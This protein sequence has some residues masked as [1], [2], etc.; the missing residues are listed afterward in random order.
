M[1]H[2]ANS[3]LAQLARDDSRIVSIST[4]TDATFARAWETTPQRMFLVESGVPYALQWCADLALNGSRPFAFLSCEEAQNSFGQI[5]QD[6]CLRRAPVTMILE[7]RRDALDGEAA[8]SASLAGIRQL[9]HTCLLAPK[10]AMEVREMITWCASQNGPAVIWLPENVEPRA[11]WQPGPDIALG[12]AE[13]LTEGND[14]A[15]IAWG[16]MVASAC[17]AAETLAQLGVRAAVLNARFAQPL[18]I[19]ALARVTRGALCTVIVNDGDNHGGFSSWVLDELLG[20]GTAQN[21]SVVSP[22]REW[23]RQH[24]HQVHDECAA[25]IVERCRWLGERIET[26][27][28]TLVEPVAG[29]VPS[30]A[31]AP[32]RWLAPQGLAVS[33]VHDEQGEIQA[34]QFTPLVD[35]WVRRYSNVGARDVYLWR[36]CLHGLGLITLSCAPPRLRQDLCDTKLLAV[37]YGVMLDDI[38]DQ[39]GEEDFLTE[40]ANIIRGVPPDFSRFSSR[41]QAY[42]RFTD[43]LWK[44]FESRLKCLPCYD[45]YKELLEYDHQQI[46]NTM[47]YSSLVNRCPALLNVQEHDMYLP[48]N[49]QMLS[50]ATMDLMASP[51]F[52]RRELGKLREVI[53][54]AQ[55][56]GR[57]GNLVS[58]WQR[59]VGD[60]DF[61]SG[62]FARA[63]C[64]GDITLEDLRS[65]P[66]GAIAEAICNGGH[67]FYF[68][69][70]WEFHRASIEALGPRIHSVDVGALL[71]ALQ[72]LLHMELGSRGFK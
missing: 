60:R 59:E 38:A 50:F 31:T 5:R 56:M 35:D 33:E 13:Q 4:A 22:N 30:G 27:S 20:L 21:V 26:Q 64:Q 48:H 51:D 44:T 54:H 70:K 12:R 29:I 28:Q 23:R 52:D 49:M 2:V 43:D 11:V 41:Q 55:S 7:S 46:L 9:P 1:R 40:L 34:Q 62:V 8:S 63:L 37:M 72:R 17:A 14:V 67:E 36:W 53:W 71:M 69:Q 65:A 10:N 45:E 3:E 24:S 6:I 42:A 16:P 25:R 61:T 32:Q 57:I 15:I 18:D 39:G 66:P 47:S 19:E 58:T 68:L